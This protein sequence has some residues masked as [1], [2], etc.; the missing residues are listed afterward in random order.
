MDSYLGVDIGGTHT[1]LLLMTE[2]GEF[3]GLSKCATRSWAG[4][5][6]PLPALQKML[7]SYLGEQK[8][9]VKGAMLGLPGIIAGDA[10]RVVSLPFVPGLDGLPVGELLS[11]GLGIPCAIDK[12][13]NHLLRWDLA[14]QP[15]RPRTAVGIYLGTGFGNSI[16][17]NHDF[18]RGSHGG[19]GELGHI[20][21]PGNERPCPCG[22]QGCVETLTSGA[23]LADWW[24]EQEPEA[25]M[26]TLF[27]RYSEQLALREFVD[28]LARVIATEMNILEPELLFLGG[29]VLEMLDFPREALLRELQRHLRAPYPATTL[30][31]HWPRQEHDT[32]VKGACLAAQQLFGGRA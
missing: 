31:V 24:Q 32:G 9:R 11:E 21:W 23:Y 8:T 10:T 6:A 16:W 20:P 19:A 27:S 28:R 26:G 17:L 18:Y 4:Q 5:P 12:D 3:H 7:Q 2:A 29:G 22:K 14:Q 15:I 25:E 13:V 30:A 1:R